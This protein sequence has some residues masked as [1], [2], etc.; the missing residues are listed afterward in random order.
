VNCFVF[1]DEHGDGI[2]DATFAMK[3]GEAPGQEQWQDLPATYHNRNSSFSFADGHSEI[4]KWHD[5]RTIVP[6]LGTGDSTRWNGIVLNRSVD[7][8]WMMEHAPYK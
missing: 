1:L 4:I 3:Y 5:P 8:E 7:Y 2:N 6:V